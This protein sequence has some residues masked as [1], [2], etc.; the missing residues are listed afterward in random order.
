MEQQ[1]TRLEQVIGKL[2]IVASVLLL[3]RV[4]FVGIQAG[5]SA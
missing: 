3:A 1:S 5:L 4:L 2:V